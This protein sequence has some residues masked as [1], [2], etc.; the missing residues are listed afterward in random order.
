MAAKIVQFMFYRAAFSAQNNILLLRHD[1]LWRDPTLNFIAKG[2]FVPISYRL[3]SICHR[4]WWKNW[5]K[6]VTNI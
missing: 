4:P 6:N 1:Q 3:Q 2:I 5:A